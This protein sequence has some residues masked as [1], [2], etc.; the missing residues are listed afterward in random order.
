MFNGAILQQ[1]FVVDYIVENNMCPD[2]NRANANPNSW[3]ASLQLRQHV[4]H[5]RTFLFL[6]Q[7]ILKH[8]AAA[9][10]VKVRVMEGGG[11]GGGA[12][13]SAAC[14]REARSVRVC[15]GGGAS[16]CVGRGAD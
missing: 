11:G 4:F 13:A 10:C 6:E 12:T 7:L 16:R 8:G 9:N 3:N 15:E 1:S 2:C 14:G 5:K